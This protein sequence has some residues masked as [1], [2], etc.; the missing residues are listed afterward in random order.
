MNMSGRR[1]REN[2]SDGLV[3][4]I[5]NSI[6]EGIG[7]ATSAINSPDNKNATQILRSGILEVTSGRVGEEGIAKEPAAGPRV[8]SSR[9]LL[10]T[11]AISSCLNEGF[12]RYG[13]ITH[14]IG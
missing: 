2:V 13:E 12:S 9:E 8:I 4:L 3:P 5:I 7:H 11:L 1:I 14:E 6:G 10:S